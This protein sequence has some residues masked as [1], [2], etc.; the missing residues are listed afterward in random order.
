MAHGFC[1]RDR[2]CSSGSCI[3]WTMVHAR[4]QRSRPLSRLRAKRSCLYPSLLMARLAT[5]SPL[6]WMVSASLMP[7]GGANRGH[8]ASAHRA[9]AFALHRPLH[10]LNLGRYLVNSAGH[11][12]S[13]S[14]CRCDQLDGGEPACQTTFRSGATRSFD[15]DCRACRAGASIDDPVL[16]AVEAW[17]DEHLL[18][19]ILPCWRASLASS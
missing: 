10:R 3:C 1:F 7:A 2:L 4:L 19:V 12:V 9:D 8:R 17:I 18:G 6:V 13:V 5:L 14:G 16:P 11:V 15:A